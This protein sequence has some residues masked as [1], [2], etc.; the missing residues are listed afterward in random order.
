MSGP[1][2]FKVWTANYQYVNDQW[3]VLSRERTAMAAR[4]ALAGSAASAE[5]TYATKAAKN[6]PKQT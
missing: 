5:G 4:A 2:R 6:T 1:T 3:M